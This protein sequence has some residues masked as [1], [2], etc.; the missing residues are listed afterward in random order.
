MLPV[1]DP[2]TVIFNRLK[3]SSNQYL[4]WFDYDDNGLQTIKRLIE[5]GEGV[6]ET[7]DK[8]KTFYA[9]VGSIYV[10]NER[11]VADFLVVEEAETM[12]VFALYPGY[13]QFIEVI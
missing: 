9:F 8:G 4:P 1:V 2:K 12:R 3:E 6:W 7:D 5:D 13:M 10:D 11:I